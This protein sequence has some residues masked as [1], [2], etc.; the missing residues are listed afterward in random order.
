MIF[1]YFKNESL[2]KT[3]PAPY[4]IWCSAVFYS[5]IIPEHDPT[6]KSRVAC[7]I[8]KNF[9]WFKP[10]SFLHAWEMQK[11]LGA[12]VWTV[13]THPHNQTI[14]FLALPSASF[15]H[16]VFLPRSRLLQ[17]AATHRSHRLAAGR[18]LF[19]IYAKFGATN[20]NRTL[21]ARLVR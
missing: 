13:V 6:K 11:K 19:P 15:F 14:V 7:L 3:K 4:R 10:S 9:K 2:K 21:L 16:D 8:S 5:I 17:G 12:G 20:T 1:L 18:F